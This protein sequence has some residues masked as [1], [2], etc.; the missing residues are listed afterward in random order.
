M[1][2]DVFVVS[3]NIISPV[4]NTAA[5]NFS[6]LINNISGVKEH[7]LPAMSPVPFYASLLEEDFAD[8]F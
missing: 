7:V 2:M 1:M 3:D 8:F 6:A 5:A 4:G